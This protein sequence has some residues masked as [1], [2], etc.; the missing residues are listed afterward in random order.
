MKFIIKHSFKIIYWLF[1]IGLFFVV[2]VRDSVD[3]VLIT[4][5]INYYFW[6]SFGLASGIYL[7][8]LIIKNYDKSN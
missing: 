5:I 6:Y 4:Q 7:S 8:G 2:F 1:I 3:N